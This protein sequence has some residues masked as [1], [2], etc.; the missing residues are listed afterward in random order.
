MYATALCWNLHINHIFKTCGKAPL[1][2]SS[3]DQSSSYI[4]HKNHCNHESYRIYINHFGKFC[5]LT[6]CVQDI[7]LTD[8]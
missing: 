7:I 8:L 5:Y 1:S 3:G 6:Y 4:S 2:S